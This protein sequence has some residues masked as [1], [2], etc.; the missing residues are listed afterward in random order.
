MVTKTQKISISKKIGF[1]SSTAFVTGNM[2]GSGI[3][4]L[5]STL[6][7]YGGISLIGWICSSL[8]AI[9]LALVFGHLGRLVPNSLGGPYAYA[10]LGLG[11]FWGYLVA[12][13]YW[14]S[15]WCTNAAIAVAFVGYLEVFIPSLKNNVTASIGS[16]LFV[17]WFFTWINSKPLKTI[18]FVQVLTTLLKLA[19]ILAMGFI[20]IFYIQLDHFIVFNLSEE[21]SF[22]AITITTTATL[23]AYLGMESAAINS[24]QIENAEN[25]IKKATITGTLITIVT[26]IL[27]SI[28]VMGI[29]PPELLSQSHAPFADAAS[30]FWGSQ[31]R[32]IVAA[33]A[34]IAT[35]G[36]LNGWIL[37]QGQ[38]PLAAAQDQLFPQFFK[39]KNKNNAP[40]I[41]IVLSSILATVVM[42]FRFSETLVNTFTFIMNLST[43][44]VITPYLLSAM[45]LIVLVRRKQ[46]PSKSKKTILALLAICFC[47][48]VCF[49]MGKEV[50]FWGFILILLGIP[51]YIYQTYFKKYQS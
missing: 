24:K 27:S 39:R 1:W 32:Y 43:L 4:L 26:Y 21:S 7:A 18:A 41:G 45:S 46:I 29:V 31:A 20:G 2:I 6:A 23:F 33:G 14:I 25:T 3:F 47:I 34:I 5:P 48:W 30:L 19:P 13:G 36:A 10:R 16:G 11:D 22:K 9:L 12:W 35:L 44:S 38:I 42:S 51:F 49:G 50:I 40:F 15:I 28:A 37:I 17:I 8:G